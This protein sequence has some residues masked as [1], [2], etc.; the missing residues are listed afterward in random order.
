MAETAMVP[1]DFF[2]VSF[3]AGT[4]FSGDSVLTYIPEPGEKAEGKDEKTDCEMNGGY[5]KEKL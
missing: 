5:V 2:S 3:I 4:F 1:I